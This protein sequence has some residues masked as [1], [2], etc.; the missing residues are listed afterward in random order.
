M[1]L[2]KLRLTQ[3]QVICVLF[4]SSMPDKR[5]Q[6]SLK[7]L[8]FAL[9]SLCLRSGTQSQFP[10]ARFILHFQPYFRERTDSIPGTD[11]DTAI[12]TLLKPWVPVFHCMQHDDIGL[13]EP[14]VEI[15]LNNDGWTF[16]DSS[17]YQENPEACMAGNR[18]PG[19]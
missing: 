15:P 16:Q 13:T 14:I 18:G 9:S 12:V 2:L 4:S 3:R 17:V 11:L 6:A 7:C 5:S 19:L 8:L 10:C 1:Q